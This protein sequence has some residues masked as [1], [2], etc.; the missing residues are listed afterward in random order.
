M[1]LRKNLL[2]PITLSAAL[3]ISLSITAHANVSYN[4]TTASDIRSLTGGVILQ[5]PIRI[6]T[7]ALPARL[8]GNG[9]ETATKFYRFGLKHYTNGELD[10]AEQDFK[11]V[12]R[13]KGLNKQALY[14]LAK[15]SQEQGKDA[16][17]KEY[18]IKFHA[19]QTKTAR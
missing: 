1:R 8:I 12:L 5:N 6:E 11:A 14:Y 15:V 9:S 10:K 19:L 17:A 16:Q 3:M 2:S 7:N 13:A 18:A 4:N